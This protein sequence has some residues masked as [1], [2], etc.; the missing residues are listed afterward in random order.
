MSTQHYAES[1]SKYSGVQDEVDE[2]DLLSCPIFFILLADVTL[3]VSEVLGAGEIMLN[4]IDMDGQC[5]GYV[6]HI[7]VILADYTVLHCLVLFI[8]FISCVQRALR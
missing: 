5:A 8:S 3:Q 1:P 4:C 7:P 6:L 2:V